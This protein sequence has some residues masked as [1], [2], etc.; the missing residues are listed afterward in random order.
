MDM[1]NITYT[2]ARIVLSL[3]FVASGLAGLFFATHT[4]PPSPPGLAGAF[5]DVYFKSHWVV[6]VDSIQL[7]AGILLLINRY[8]PLA[9]ITLAGIITNIFIF[10][11]TMAP[12]GLPIVIVL[13]AL[14]FAAVW[15]LRAHFAP[16]LA[17]KP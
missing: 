9:L 8:A 1:L 14:W 11:M 4:P 5:Q 13:A 2:A 15:P 6:Y 3:L 10:H 16:L 12:M 17:R 7:I